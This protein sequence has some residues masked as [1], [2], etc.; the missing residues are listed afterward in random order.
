MFTGGSGDCCWTVHHQQTQ[1]FQGSHVL[2]HLSVHTNHNK[3]LV[4][5]MLKTGPLP[6]R[7]V[8]FL[9]TYCNIHI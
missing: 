5:I 2:T 7:D 6:T 8:Y 1:G 3:S 9:F 4:G